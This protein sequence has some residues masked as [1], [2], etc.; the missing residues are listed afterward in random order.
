MTDD[1][2][3]RAKTPRFMRQLMADF[4]F[5]KLDAA[6]VFG[7]AGHESAGFKAMQEIQPTGGRGGYGWFQWTGARRKAFEAYCA[8][9]ALAPESD[10]ANYAWLFVELSGREKR[11]VTAVKN[12][13]GLRSK[14]E[15]F[16]RTFERA[17]VK[18]YDSRER[19]A[20]IALAAFD[21]AP[22]PDPV[23]SPPADKPA[24]PL[25]IGAIGAL[26]ATIVGAILNAFGLI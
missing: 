19:W 3:F 24:A 11:A 12:A 13:S 14:V 20:R 10:G 6:A 1:A 9:N 25:A 16:E 22:M 21:A 8:R 2:L 26:I 18:H 15:A 23:P 7:N 17:G 4:S 5:D